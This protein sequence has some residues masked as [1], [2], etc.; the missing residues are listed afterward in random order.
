MITR[1]ALYEHRC[2]YC[3]DM[4]TTRKAQ[5]EH[6]GSW[7]REQ[8]KHRGWTQ[9]E[10]AGRMRRNKGVVGNWA[11]GNR[12]PDPVSCDVLADALFIDRD[13]V[14]AEAGHRT[15][16][17]ETPVN[18]RESRAA[19]L[20]RRIDWTSGG[21]LLNGLLLSMESFATTFPKNHTSE[22]M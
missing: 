20:V 3:C 8:L 9:T 5:A 10:L 2:N 11:R 7:L 18:E 4:T 1:L 17:Y 16:I 15:V 13:I 12:I 19:E 14:L 21:E 22:K 6:F